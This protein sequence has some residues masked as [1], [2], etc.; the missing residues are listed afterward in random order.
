[1]PSDRE[2]LESETLEQLTDRM[3]H[4]PE[5]GRHYHAAVA[6]LERRKA[7][8]TKQATVAQQEAAKAAERTA[9]Y[10]RR[11]AFFMLLSVFAVLVG[12]FIGPLLPHILGW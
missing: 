12:S 2:K 7:L 8:W 10:T 6:E 11:A 3:Q 9:Q 1:V 5:S 4:G